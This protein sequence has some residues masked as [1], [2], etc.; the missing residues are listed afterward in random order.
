MTASQSSS[1]ML[2]SIRSRVIPA[3]LTTMPSPP[4]PSAVSTSSSAVARWL[5][6]PATATALDP[7][8]VISSMTSDASSAAGDVV[9]HDRRAGAGQADRLGAAQAR[10]RTGHHR[11]QSGQI[12]RVSILR[13][14]IYEYL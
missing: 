5:M 3:L 10:G 1:V 8:A 12:G 14:S 7:A 4:S 9:D 2:N 11:D 6:S 13:S